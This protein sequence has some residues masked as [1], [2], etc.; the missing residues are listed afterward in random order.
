MTQLEKGPFGGF[1]F[2]LI[3]VLL[4]YFRRNLFYYNLFESK[5]LQGRLWVRMNSC[6]AWTPEFVLR[7]LCFISVECREITEMSICQH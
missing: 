7:A 1:I 6:N 2:D 3:I 4:L 5:P